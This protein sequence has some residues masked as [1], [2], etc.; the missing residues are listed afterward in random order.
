MG[1]DIGNSRHITRIT[2]EELHLT[3]TQEDIWDIGDMD[4]SIL[5]TND[6]DQDSMDV[7]RDLWV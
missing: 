6:A 7:D 3:S 4:D 1:T 2:F 5:S